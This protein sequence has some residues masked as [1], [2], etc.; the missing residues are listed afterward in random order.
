LCGRAGIA[1]LL[2]GH[3]E[4]RPGELHGAIEVDADSKQPMS[5]AELL[6]CSSETIRLDARNHHLAL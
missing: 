6:Q 4:A 2:P 5:L 1:L 3:S